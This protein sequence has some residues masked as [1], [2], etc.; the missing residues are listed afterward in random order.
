MKTGTFGATRRAVSSTRCAA[1]GSFI[2]STSSR[3]PLQVRVPERLLAGGVA[4][5][6]RQPERLPARTFSA[7]SSSTTNGPRSGRSA[8]A[9]RAAPR[10]PKPTITTCPSMVLPVSS[11]AS[12]LR[13]P[14]S[15]SS[16]ASSR[17]P[18]DVRRDPHQQRRE[19]HARDAGR[20]QGLRSSALIT[21]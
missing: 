3:A 13:T 18:R 20:E 9:P 14:I 21:P 17:S 11:A 4:V 7:L 2:S 15:R 6:H 1:C 8:C 5:I 19:E 16:G 10:A 12:M